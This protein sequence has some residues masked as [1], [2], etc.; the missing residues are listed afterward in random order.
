MDPRSVSACMIHTIL[1]VNMRTSW[2]SYWCINGCFIFAQ[3][4][5][6]NVRCFI[7]RIFFVF[8]GFWFRFFCFLWF[9]VSFWSGLDWF[10]FGLIWFDLGF[11]YE[12]ESVWFWCRF[13]LVR[14]VLVRFEVVRCCCLV[15]FG[16]IWLGVFFL[17]LL[18]FGLLW[19]C[20]AF[21]LLSLPLPPQCT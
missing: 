3:S 7:H 15:W 4:G 14:F 20:S 2:S 8:C 5:T 18:V 19:S 11:D 17:L 12:I 21:A 10:W 13:W 6:K 1:I 16:W 9:L